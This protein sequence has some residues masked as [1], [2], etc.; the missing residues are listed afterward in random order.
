M[1]NPACTIGWHNWQT[2]ARNDLTLR[3]YCPSCGAVKTQ[4][5]IAR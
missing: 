2:P 3:A 5:A 1:K 4:P